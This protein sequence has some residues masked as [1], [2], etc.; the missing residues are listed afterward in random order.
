MNGSTIHRK[1]QQSSSSDPLGD[2]LSERAPPSNGRPTLSTRRQPQQNVTIHPAFQKVLLLLILVV[3]FDAHYVYQFFSTSTD[4]EHAAAEVGVVNMK[5]ARMDGLADHVISKLKSDRSLQS[6]GVINSSTKLRKKPKAEPSWKTDERMNPDLIS[7]KEIED[8]YDNAVSHHSQQKPQSKKHKIEPSWKTDKRM[9]PAYNLEQGINDYEDKLLERTD[10]TS[11]DH[12]GISSERFNSLN[13]NEKI[14][15]LQLEVQ[16]W[17]GRYDMTSKKLHRLEDEFTKYGANL[18]G[19]SHLPDHEVNA[20]LYEG[21]DVEAVNQ[22][23]NKLTQ[24]DDANELYDP[25]KTDVFDKSEETYGV[26]PHILKIL[27]AAGVEIDEELATILPTWED[28]VSMYGSKPIIS[29]LETCPEYRAEVK[30]EDRMTGPAGMFNTGTN[31]LY[32]LLKANCVIE[33]ARLKPR[34]EPKHNGM[35]WQAPVS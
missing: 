35:R 7:A 21:L 13:P 10:E 8:R 34:R 15:E 31:L 24:Q 16:L 5:S 3:L 18:A 9:N 6:D 4:S 19:T 27:Q 17:K 26:D 14:E 2:F 32:E 1:S 29:G 22:D 12:L 23:V 20:L 25:Y 33:E 11:V 28:I 30:P